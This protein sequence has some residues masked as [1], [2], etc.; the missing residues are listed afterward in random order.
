MRARTHVLKEAA[1]IVVTNRGPVL[2]ARQVGTRSAQGQP[3]APNAPLRADHRPNPLL[4]RTPVDAAQCGTAFLLTDLNWKP[5][6]TNDAAVLILH[7]PDE[8]RAN[9][10]PAAVQ[11]RIRS[12]FK[13]EHFTT[14]SPPTSF[15]SGRRHYVCR[16]FLLESHNRSPIIALVLERCPRGPVELSRVSQRFH[17][18]RRESETVQHLSH[19]LTTKEVAQ[20]M[21]VSPNT[22]K[23][24]VRLIMSKMRVTRRSGIIGKLLGG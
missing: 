9:T 18:S 20:R 10:N 15:L 21:G 14:G 3:Q 5:I 17:L 2:E 8:A 16:P 13:A 19:G 12:I 7:Y 1:T 4:A 11:E 23:Q 22:V 6:Y 24:F